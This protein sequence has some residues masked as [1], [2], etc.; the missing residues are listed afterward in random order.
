MLKFSK[1]IN[2]Y[3]Q[4]NL[5]KLIKSDK[6]DDVYKLLKE[7]K[8]DFFNKDFALQ[9]V[10]LLNDES[11]RVRGLASWVLFTIGKEIKLPKEL[12]DKWEQ[13]ISKGKLKYIWE[14]DAG[15]CS[16]TVK[17][18]GDHG[19]EDQPNNVGVVL[20]IAK[21]PSAVSVP[22]I[23]ENLDEHYFVISGKG[24]IWLKNPEDGEEEIS[25]LEPGVA[26]LIPRKWPIQFRGTD[27]EKPLILLV[28]TNPPYRTIQHLGPVE[29][30]LDEGYWKLNQEKP[31][32]NQLDL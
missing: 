5:I 27:V 17:V 22:V 10:S 29:T 30:V 7:Q 28:V 9:L 21:S 4:K 31:K 24:E 6:Y 26:K 15:S 19:N 14:G 2:T 11:F 16:S 12:F 20:A 25:I 32:V 3:N 13:F 8:N 1:T 18:L 23:R